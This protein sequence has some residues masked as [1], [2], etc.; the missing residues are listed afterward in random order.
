MKK[1][2]LLTFIVIFG[3][4]LFLFLNSQ[5]QQTQN[6]NQTQN[7]TQTEKLNVPA[8][9]LNNSSNVLVAVGDIMLSRNVGTKIRTLNDPKAPFLKTVEILKSA[10]ITFGNLES[11]F[12]DKGPPLT[13]GMVFK[14]EPDTIAGLVYA[15]FDILSLAN[16]HF[17]NRGTSGMQYTFSHLLNNKIQYIGAGEN[18]AKA[19]EV[20]II[21]KKGIKFAF[22]GYDDMASTITPTSYQATTST[23][24]VAPLIESSLTTDIKNA[25]EKAD[26]VI[27]SFHWGNEYKQIQ[28]DRQTKVGRLAIDSG[29]S[30]VLGHH[31]HVVEPYEKYKDGYVFYSLGNF[32]FDQMWSEATRKGEIAKVYFKGV[33][34]E[35]VEVIPIK[36]YDYY[37]PKIE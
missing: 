19:K 35:K 5:K 33:K 2:Y 29:A 11:P 7:L 30:L 26:A 25:K 36:I 22:L 6:Q 27:V 9:T 18:L 31:P 32:V 28:N 3:V 16:N 24:G 20:K 23:P 8:E 10:D 21:E 12:D 15:G 13:Q 14:A 37:Q 17:G 4:F 1:V 34:I